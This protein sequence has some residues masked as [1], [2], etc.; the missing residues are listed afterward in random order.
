MAI[1]KLDDYDLWGA[2][3]V[4]SGSNDEIL[5][6][7][8]QML[9]NREL[10]RIEFSSEPITKEKKARIKDIADIRLQFS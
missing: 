1:L 8:C 3:K 4:W 7:L 10:F 6:K 5:S 2:I 9:L